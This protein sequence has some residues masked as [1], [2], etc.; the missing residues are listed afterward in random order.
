MS[1]IAAYSADRSLKGKLRRRLVRLAA[2]RPAKRGPGRAMVSF[3]F[4]DAPV[5]AVSEGRA[6]LES[7]GLHGTYFVAAELAGRTGPM[8]L[9]ASAD[10]LMQAAAAGHE[11]ACHTYSHLDCGQADR[12]A[13]EADVARNSAALGAWGAAPATTFAYPYGDVSLAAKR[14]LGGRYDLLRGLHHGLVEAGTDLN[15]APAVGIEG[16]EG[17]VLVREWIDRAIERRAWLIVYTHD[18]VAAPSPFGCTPGALNRLIDHALAHQAEIV[19]VAEGARRLA[20]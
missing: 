15:Q 8:G 7:R 4:D 13:I 16:P 18:V 19:T 5:T 9:N 14:A 3:S 6:A 17:E 2:R 1:E 12:A 20:N 11:I 10:A